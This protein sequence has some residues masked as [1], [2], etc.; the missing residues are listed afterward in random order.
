MFLFFGPG[1]VPGYPFWWIFP[2]LFGALSL[3]FIALL[4]LKLRY[5]GGGW[6]HGET[7]QDAI[8]VLKERF[9]R[10]EIDAEEYEGRRRVLGVK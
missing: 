10:G 1:V 8:D 3:L 7:R 2:L 6:A 5:W 4:I 9:A